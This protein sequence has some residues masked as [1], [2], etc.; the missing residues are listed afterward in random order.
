P[1]SELGKALRGALDG[2]QPQPRW[3]ACEATAYRRGPAPAPG[4]T[5]L[6]LSGGRDARSCPESRSTLRVTREC[7][8]SSAASVSSSTTGTLAHPAKAA[9]RGLLRRRRHVA[10]QAPWATV[11]CID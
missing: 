10:E 7:C 5:E 2:V 3:P 4:A 1:A 6:G 8:S 11:A 9:V